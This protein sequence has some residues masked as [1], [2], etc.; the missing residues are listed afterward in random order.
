MKSMID[1]IN[2]LGLTVGVIAWI[3][4]QMFVHSG[5]RVSTV[6]QN[7]QNVT[8]ATCFMPQYLA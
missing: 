4:L 3:G 8:L 7:L 5:C 6:I 1:Q 2:G